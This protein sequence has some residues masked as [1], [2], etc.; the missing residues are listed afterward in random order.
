MVIEQLIQ[1]SPLPRKGT[2]IDRPN[3]FPHF[4]KRAIAPLNPPFRQGRDPFF[5]FYIVDTLRPKGT[6]I[7]KI[8]QP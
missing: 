3:C 4:F 1:F 7:L 8:L 2:L 6:E 5:V